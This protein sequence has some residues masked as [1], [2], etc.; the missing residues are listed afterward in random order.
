M[1]ASHQLLVFLLQV[2]LLLAAATVLGILAARLGL[3]AVVGEL[4]AGVLLGPSLLG[5]LAPRFTT[6]LFPPSAGQAHLLDAVG[7]LGAILLVGVIGADLDTRMIRPIMGTVGRISVLSLAIPF[8]LGLACG[9]LTPTAL[10]PYHTD[11]RAFALLLAVALSVSAI[12][13]IAKTLNDMR[14]MH[15]DLG[16]LILAT[17]TVDDAVAWFG[18]SVVSA[19]AVAGAT[20]AKFAVSALCLG[21]FL[22]AAL[23]IGRPLVRLAVA[24]TARFSE[25]AGVLTAVAFLVIL[26]GGAASDALGFEAVF[27]AFVA[28]TLLTAA[29]VSRVV[30]AR[31]KTIVMAV[32]APVF[33]ASAGLR[34]DVTTLRHP[35]V[36]ATTLVLLV[37]AVIGKFAGGYAGGRF[38]RL[39][40]YESMAVGAGLNSRGVV[41][42]VIAMAG[43][44][45][46]LFSIT[47]YTILLV[48]AVGTSIMTVP[49]L[50]FAMKHITEQE[51]EQRRRIEF[52]P[53]DQIQTATVAG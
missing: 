3:P 43:L 53:E 33:L 23:V 22:V 30:L 49:M 13:V 31:L 19:M 24:R 17:A 47:V 2:V 15:R 7:Q 44:R 46:G 40:A 36:I 18:L 35:A 12:P 48:V 20:G 6:W 21:G 42:I 8:G 10:I 26:L 41:Q 14:L 29:D 39:G 34:M 11:R 32:L 4:M 16:Q 37:T 50:R 45:L 52:L 25:P 9:F 27:G 1:L 51:H 38:S 5:H 28:G